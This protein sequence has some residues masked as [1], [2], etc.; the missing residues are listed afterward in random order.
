MNDYLQWGG[1]PETV[2][3]EMTDDVKTELLQ[4]YYES[5]VLKDCV[6]TAA[7]GI[8]SCFTGFFTFSLQM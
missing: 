2:L 6:H 3:H 8:Q 5:I 4:S 1:F 7:S